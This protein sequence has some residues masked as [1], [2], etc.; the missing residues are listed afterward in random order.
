VLPQLHFKSWFSQPIFNL[1]PKP[2]HNDIIIQFDLI[3]L[4]WKSFMVSYCFSIKWKHSIQNFS[5]PTCH[6]AWFPL[7]SSPVILGSQFPR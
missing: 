2:C 3:A 1:S 7:C 4:P 5:C 6:S